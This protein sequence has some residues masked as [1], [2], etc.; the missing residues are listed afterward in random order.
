M[1][2]KS[3]KCLR[4]LD[5][6]VLNIQ[7]IHNPSC[8][9]IYYETGLSAKFCIAIVCK[10]I[11][12]NNKWVKGGL[13]SETSGTLQ[14]VISNKMKTTSKTPDYIIVQFDGSNGKCINAVYVN[15]D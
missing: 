3:E 5:K 4:K 12:T 15:N 7:A 8:V 13:A 2:Y 9:N 1:N 6:P 14:A 10:V 11:I